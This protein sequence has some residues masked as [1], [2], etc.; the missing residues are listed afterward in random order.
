MKPNDI[1][2]LTNVGT[3]RLSPDGTLVAYTVARIDLGGNRYREQVWLAP[4][5]GGATPEPFSSGKYRDRHPVW[6]PDG[7]RLAYI[8]NEPD[9]TQTTVWIAPL[10]AGS[11]VPLATFPDA[12]AALAWSPDGTWLAATARTPDPRFTGEVSRQPPRRIERFFSRLDTIGWLHGR[13]AHV[14]LVATD[15]SGEQR[16][17]TPGQFEHEGATW[18]PDSR[19]IVFSAARHDTWDLD[20]AN[21]IYAAD[22]AS[23]QLRAL[24]DGDGTYP[25]P[26]VSPAIATSSSSA[27]R[28]RD[29]SHNGSPVYSISNRV[30]HLVRYRSRSHLQ[31]T[32]TRCCGLAATTA[33]SSPRECGNLTS[34]KCRQTVNHRQRSSSAG[35]APS[36]PSTSRDHRRFR[37]DRDRP[38]ERAR[39]SI[40][41]R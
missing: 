24:T 33:C 10:G 12:V 36:P 11:P 20:L 8:T 17:L 5:V 13:H 40:E 34:T 23:G 25:A 35:N 16:D 9:V 22:V 1:G 29:V 19:T 2:S 15:G 21:D 31:R 27:P 28:T 30:A 14:H 41:R 3:V 6:S 32:I 38:A 26:A 18:S 4:T 37:R 7:R 39:R